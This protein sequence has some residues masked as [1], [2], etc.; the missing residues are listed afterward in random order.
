MKQVLI[1]EDDEKKNPPKK[2]ELNPQEVNK[3]PKQNEEKNKK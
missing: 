3:N 1:I 2:T